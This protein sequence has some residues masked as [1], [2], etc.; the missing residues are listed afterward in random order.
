M[1]RPIWLWLLVAAAVAGMA[2]PTHAQTVQPQARTQR[3]L[4]LIASLTYQSSA[5]EAALRRQSSAQL[6]QLR[7]QIAA[8]D[9]AL[10]RAYGTVRRSQTEA[11]AARAERLALERELTAL[12]QRFAVDLSA[13]DPE[14]ASARTRIEVAA[15]ELLK[16]AEG[17]RAL[18]VYLSNEPGS[19][20][21]A[22]SIAQREAARRNADDRRASSDT[23]EL[24]KRNATDKRAI[25]TAF[26]TDGLGKGRLT[27]AFVVKLWQDVVAAD[28]EKHW[29]WVQLSRLYLE[30]NQLDAAA[31]AAERAK[32]T[33]TTD[34]DRAVALIELGS[35]FQVR[36]DFVSAL[37]NYRQSLE[38]ARKIAKL[39]PSATAW[40]DVAV[41]QYRVCKLLS[42][43]NAIAAA[44]DSCRETLDISRRLAKLTG[45]T[46]AQRDLSGILAL[47]GSLHS[48][49]NETVEAIESYKESLNIARNI[50]QLEL[51][52]IE[53][54]LE[55]SDI[56]N[57][58]GDVY[59][60]K[61]DLRAALSYYAESLNIV[62][63][64]SRLDRSSAFKLNQLAHTLDKVGYVYASLGDRPNSI[65]TFQE[66]LETRRR[67]VQFNPTSAEA[68]GSVLL[69]LQV[70]AEL[71]APGYP[72]SL[73]AAQA[74]LMEKN[75]QLRPA[76]SDRIALIR[77]RA[78]EE[79]KA[80]AK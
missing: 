14:F 62:R 18:E 63:N 10:Q 49:R 69:A 17:Q 13:K 26:G 44:L 3:E 5:A 37:G 77:Q 76:D 39:E 43:Q 2:V 1:I 16:T 38:I 50:S 48:R 7:S 27:A 36:G 23:R 80:T 22:I 9:A 64:I 47:I 6:S 41:S 31:R 55:L 33:G 53:K 45:G 19:A 68:Q 70:L 56:L 35:V 46:D 40:R 30:L 59:L 57:G 73:A 42:L 58:L 75:R 71:R 28:P 66:L 51:S 65:S 4:Y 25:A 29:D 15:T 11:A 67:L 34:R 8:K 79:A 78:E 61:D 24:A 60:R 12:K 20:E 32:T 54:K 21:T 74:N 52:S 72:W